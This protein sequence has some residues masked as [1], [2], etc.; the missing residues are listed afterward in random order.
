MMAV[1]RRGSA[2]V[3]LFAL[4]VLLFA[5]THRYALTLPGFAEDI[6][7]V[8]QL[9]ADAQSGVLHETL[10][11]RVIGPLWGPGST[12]WR[13]WAFA[14]LGVDAVAYG[15]NAGMWHVTN[16][17]LHLAG[18]LFTAVLAHRMLATT[19]ASAAAFATAL[20]HPWTAEITLWLV[21]RFDGWASAAMLVALWAASRSKKL[22]RWLVTSL[23]FGAI[24]FASKES[25]LLLPV[26]IMMLC[27]VLAVT[28][29]HR[30]ESSWRAVARSM[31]S[32]WPLV[33]SHLM[34]ALAYLAC[35]HSFVQNVGVNVYAQAPITSFAN[36]VKRLVNHV[37]SF[38]GLSPLAPW[39]ALVV[40]V[41]AITALP[42]ALKTTRS[43]AVAIMGLFWA[44][45]VF[46]GAALHF[47]GTPGVGDGSRL[48]YLALFGFALVAAASVTS[49][50][51]SVATWIVAAW[52][53]ALSLWQNNVNGEWWIAARVEKQA[54]NAI[55][56]TVRTTAAGDYGL[57]MMPDPVGRVPM[58]RNAQGAI[59]TEAQKLHPDVD[60]LSKL[61]VFLPMQ[62]NEWHGLMQSDVVRLITSNPAAPPRPTR[63]Y[64]LEPGRERLDDLGF[65]PPGSIDAWRS[66]WQTALAKH[67]PSLKL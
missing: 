59:I 47:V 39:A 4:A 15:P 2:G 54:I 38:A 36:F 16:L 37:E 65:W 53:L 20:L 26:A 24:A 32:C 7:L 23:V 10:W 56:E 66:G 62:L 28:D 52:M 58:V 22:D 43:R 61:I 60:A 67:C 14:S 17:I 29:H 57:L 51:K 44:T 42:L 9:V 21:G 55:A 63:Y 5:W 11:K 1:T 46:V 50:P 6:G 35:R 30:D 31:V 3:L 33:L 45:A 8:Q 48:Y 27:C 41:F 25:A 13:P 40:L 12:M 19:V 18:S 64:C 49:L 34:L